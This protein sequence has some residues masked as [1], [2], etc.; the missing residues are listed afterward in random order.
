MTSPGRLT[1]GSWRDT[2]SRLPTL[3]RDWRLGPDDFVLSGPV[4][5]VER[6]LD[7]WN[8][9]RSRDERTGDIVHPALVFL[10]E[11]DGTVAYAAGGDPGQIE[12]LARRMR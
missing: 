11:A 9:A 8:V 5:E 7:A 2:P 10:V 6:V 3:A 12:E 4:D 1:S